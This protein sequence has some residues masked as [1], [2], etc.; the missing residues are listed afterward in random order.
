MKVS[1]RINKPL[2]ISLLLTLSPLFNLEQECIFRISRCAGNMEMS[3]VFSCD[4]QL[5]REDSH[6]MNLYSSS[7]TGVFISLAHLVCQHADESPIG[8]MG[9]HSVWAGCLGMLEGLI[10][11]S[12]PS[13]YQV[14]ACN[15]M[16][17][18]RIMNTN[19]KW[20][21]KSENEW[22]WWKGEE[23]VTGKTPPKSALLW[24]YGEQISGF[25]TLNWELAHLRTS[26]TCMLQC[27]SHVSMSCKN[28]RGG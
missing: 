17:D 11:I 15:L 27:S 16:M 5:V 25:W 12:N 23:T 7:F 24:I 20:S 28:K 14:F 22:E 21:G 6:A 2:T 3:R 19:R 4:G 1:T 10:F 8:G 26:N 9:V 13:R 18:M